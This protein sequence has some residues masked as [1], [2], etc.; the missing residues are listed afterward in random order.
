MDLEAE[1]EQKFHD[2]INNKG[3][4]PAR[5]SLLKEERKTQQ[6]PAKNLL[7]KAPSDIFF[8]SRRETSPYF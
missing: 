6:H 8:D 7:E 1:E 2:R 3:Q 4:G 5:T